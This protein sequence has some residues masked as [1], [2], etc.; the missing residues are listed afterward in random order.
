MRETRHP[1]PHTDPRQPRH[2]TSPGTNPPVFAW[3]PVSDDRTFRLIVARDASFTDR[4]L[5]VP[6]LD[7]PMHLPS[8]AF[9]PGHYFWRW[10]TAAAQSDVFEF[11]IAPDAVVLEVPEAGEWLKRMSAQHPRFLIRPENVQRLRESRTGERSAQWAH[12]RHNA[13][14]LLMQ[15]HDLE[16]PPFLPS[17]D[18]DEGVMIWFGIVMR[19]R[20][21]VREAAQLALAYLASGEEKYGRAA[22]R[23]MLSVAA[24]NPDGSSHPTHNDEA[25]MSVIGYGSLACDWVWDLFTETE[26]GAIIASFRRRGQIIYE[27]MHDKEAYGVS[28]FDSHTGREI[29]F[30]ANIAL[31]FHDQIPEAQAWLEW[32]RPVLCGIWPIWAG[33]DG[34]WA[35][36]IH[37]S[38]N[39]VHHMSNFA[40]G[41]KRGVGVD[42]YRRPF[43]RNYPHWLQSFVPAYAEWIG[44]GDA[45][46]P[47]NCW[48]EG[49]DNIELISRELGT[50]EYAPFVAALRGP[51]SERHAQL[52]NP[53]IYLH[54]KKS[55]VATVT[56]SR[57]GIL[58][59]FPAVGWA[60]I[61]THDSD[62]SRDVAFLFR[63]SPYG[64]IS[65]SH[66]NNN[67]FIL[68]SGGK[69]LLM[70]SGYY[71]SYGSEH[72]V[73]W[74]WHTKSHNCVTLSDA[75]QI[76]NSRNSS[77][78]IENVFED[79]HLV[80]FCGNADA[81][82]S[83]RAAL[84]RRHVLFVKKGT[85]FILIDEFA[86]LPGI[87]SALQWN[88]H[89][90]NKFHVDEARRSFVVER[91][92]SSV[93]GHILCSRRSFFTM[94]EGWDPPTIKDKT[95][96]AWAQQYHLRFT[97]GGLD[98]QRNLGVILCPAHGH[99]KA[100]A[101]NTSST[102]HAEVARIGDDSVFINQQLAGTMMSVDDRQTAARAVVMIEGC[103]YDVWQEGLKKIGEA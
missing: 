46:D 55:P 31:C 29:V 12:L 6:G 3:K 57:S 64:A 51:E 48:T 18:T 26:R 87:A 91:G 84:C 58:R 39:Y 69:A 41:L 28:R 7:E 53:I 42:L 81:S 34:G 52:I 49:A 65:H 85:Y 93:T 43:W 90:W 74:V 11:D 59:H 92:G 97:P 68:H 79:E 4:V 24:W 14:A 61:R 89:S 70:P 102:G 86:A 99:L 36:G 27:L 38:S 54:D 50:E 94:S 67:D 5:D 66:A 75:P 33:D 25:H 56:E 82:Y 13:E 1:H 22:C 21:F 10:S 78:R 37:Y 9:A 62:A 15:G 95:N 103:R 60:A 16:E 30:L 20:P 73:H 32:L 71:D 96:P 101:V 98:S 72:H 83:D 2:L 44:F 100:P 23:R 45:N 76:L 19:A 35:E 17:E 47:F 77:G 63:S 80:Y 40:S 88:A 8:T